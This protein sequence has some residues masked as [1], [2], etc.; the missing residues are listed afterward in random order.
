[1]KPTAV[2]FLFCVAAS[3]V[4]ETHRLTP[5]HPEL[6]QPAILD[7]YRTGAHRITIPPGTYRITPPVTGSHL[8]FADMS[9]F[10]I[11][12]QGVHLILADQTRGG[13]EFRNCRNV[14]LRGAQI[15]YEIPPFTQGVIEGIAWTGKWYDVRIERGYPTNLDEPKYFSSHP[16]AHLFDPRFRLL[17]AGTY[18]LYPDR[19]QRSGPDRFR[20]YWNRASGPLLHP[21]AVGDLI[22]FRGAGYHSVTVI[23]CAR[24]D[25]TGVTI[26]NAG[27]FAIW[28]SGGEGENHYTVTVTRGSRPPG[29]T[30]DPLLSSTAD[31]F[32]STNVRKGPVL[33]RCDFEGMADD[34]IAIQGTYSF[35]FQANGNRL[36][37]N[38]NTFRPGDPLRLLDVASRPAGEAIVESVRP[39]ANFVSERKSRRSTRQD[40][41]AGPYF[42][43][44]LDRPLP[45]EFDFLASN[46]AASGRGYVLRGNRIRNHRA[47]GMLLKTDDGLVED[48]VIDGSSMGGIVLSPEIWWNEASYSSNVVIR[49]NTIRHVAYAPRQLGAMVIAN[50]E[51]P[52]VGCGHQHISI[53]QNV[54]EALD[55]VNLYLSSACDVSVTGN[56]FVAARNAGAVIRLIGVNRV[57]FDSN[58]V[59][60]PD[61]KRQALIEAKA[62]AQVRGEDTGIKACAQNG[63]H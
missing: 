28:E 21:V 32:H 4:P 23:D 24:V 33:E 59:I 54:F 30:A 25:L 14:R 22:A 38:Q 18:D 5:A 2:W 26:Y 1:M 52:V 63:C 44:S 16:L 8:Q 20:L 40:N 43:I 51:A 50:T 35:V 47:R 49:G 46:P 58:L 34:G 11:D 39:L 41:T 45:A 61:P 55:G 29:A 13:I 9:D 56:R 31:A 27:N 53:Q 6:F 17:K 12:A 15:A 36:V 19:I 3:A 42:A 48:N 37:I 57:G 60:A 62:S 7:A 10:E